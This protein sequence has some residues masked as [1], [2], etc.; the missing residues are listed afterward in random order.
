MKIDIRHWAISN[1][2]KIYSHSNKIL[3]LIREIFNIYLLYCLRQQFFAQVTFSSFSCTSHLKILVLPIFFF[4]NV[5]PLQKIYFEN[6]AMLRQKTWLDQS[7][8]RILSCCNFPKM[9]F[10]IFVLTTDGDWRGLFVEHCLQSILIFCKG[11][12]F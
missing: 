5:Q 3:S 9:P 8:S 1:S 6:L 4:L 12:T 10:K 11:W 7:I 2:K